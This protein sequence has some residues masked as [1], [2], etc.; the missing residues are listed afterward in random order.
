MTD[1][2]TTDLHRKTSFKARMVARLKQAVAREDGSA[3]LDFV[4]VIPILLMVFMAAFESGLLMVRH[5]MLE[6]AVDVTVRNLRLGLYP[7]PT[8]ALIKSEICDRTSILKDCNAN[9]H[10]ELSPISTATWAMPTTGTA[11][12]DRTQEIQPSLV[13]N[14]GNANEVMLVRVCVLQ[15]AIFPTSGVGLALPKD[16]A[17]GYGLVSISAFVNE[18]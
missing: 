2:K 16:A 5:I 17:G 15:D 4:M 8:A 18:P 7:N 9:I 12:V 1:C 14:P 6:Q 3:S 10:I 13:F 11:C